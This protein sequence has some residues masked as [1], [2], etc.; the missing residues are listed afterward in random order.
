MS[1]LNKYIFKIIFILK[2]KYKYLFLLFISFISLSLIDIIGISFVTAFMSLMIGSENFIFFEH[3]KSFFVYLNIYSP[4]NFLNILIYTILF[5]YISKSIVTYLIQ[6]WIIHF[7]L[8]IEAW[9]RSNLMESFLGRPYKYILNENASNIVNIAGVYTN[10]F[11]TSVLMQ[12]IKLL[13]ESIVILMVMSF[14]AY[15]EPLSVMLVLIIFLIFFFI[16]NFFVSAAISKTG[17]VANKFYGSIIKS[18]NEAIFSIKEIKIFNR[19]LHFLD[20]INKNTKTVNKARF[21][22]DALKLIPKYAIELLIILIVMS[23]AFIFINFYNYK[24]ND[25][26]I[27]LTLFAAAAFR[28]MPALTQSITSINSLRSSKIV[29]SE[30]YESMIYLENYKSQSYE[31][32]DH[33]NTNFKI[34]PFSTINL[35]NINFRYS[36]DSDYVLSNINLSIN[37]GDCIGIVGTSGSGK[38]TLI[39]LIMGLLEFD[40]GKIT[41]DNTNFVNLSPLQFSISYIPQNIYLLDDTIIRNI[42]FENNENKIDFDRLQ[43]AI[44]SAQLSKFI[45]SQPKNIHSIIGENGVKLSGGQRQRIAIARALYFER[46]IIILDE[47]TSSLDNLTEYEIVECINNL[48]GDKTIIVVA[49]RESTL[50]Y[51]DKVYLIQNGALI[52]NEKTN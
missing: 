52:R 12:G 39:N 10:T 8:N 31:T 1:S 4:S 41:I 9:L 44:E 7:S 20:Q 25:F 19:S 14:L 23:L 5:I 2:G 21:I 32:N 29:V 6:L 15:N 43:N 17:H 45:N 22:Q 16:Y 46:E 11:Q 27:L 28:L 26:I 30:I 50:K 34:T 18:I 42:T 3:I 49:H 13:S 35:E 47:A 48:R 40:D 38:T 51:C 36:M 33:G 37:K 24:N